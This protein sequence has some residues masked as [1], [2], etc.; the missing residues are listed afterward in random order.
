MRLGDVSEFKARARTEGM[1]AIV[2]IEL[3]IVVSIVAKIAAQDGV[4]L[5]SCWIPKQLARI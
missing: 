3:L 2:G 1:L 5:G 4:G